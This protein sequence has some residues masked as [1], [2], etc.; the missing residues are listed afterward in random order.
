MAIKPEGGGGIS[1]NGPANCG[2]S[3]VILERG[4]GSRSLRFW[5]W[6]HKVLDKWKEQLTISISKK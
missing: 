5:T 3:K 2:F 6:I 1:L 4:G